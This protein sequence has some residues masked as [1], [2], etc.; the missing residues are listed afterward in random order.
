MEAPAQRLTVLNSNDD[1]HS[2]A[3][4][5]YVLSQLQRGVCGKEVA[6]QITRMY[7][8]RATVERLMAYRR[9][10][11]Q[12]AGYWTMEELVR[13]HWKR[14]Y[15]LVDISGRIV[16][17]SRRCTKVAESALMSIRRH[18]CE[19]AAIS[20]EAVPLSVLWSFYLRH[21]DV[22]IAIYFPGALIAT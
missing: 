19:E 10:R 8:V 1:V 20:E 12:L 3:C 9:Y 22:S 6:D 18:L 21:E 13:H 5:D 16:P 15:A 7:L 11:E 2:Q 14:L 17:Q 4:G